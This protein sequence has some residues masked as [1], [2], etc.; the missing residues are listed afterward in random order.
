M[1]MTSPFTTGPHVVA[2][3]AAAATFDTSD[4]HVG[5]A[6]MIARWASVTSGPVEPS[7]RVVLSTTTD[8]AG[9]APATGAT[10]RAMVSRAAAAREATRD[11]TRAFITT[12]LLYTSDAADDLT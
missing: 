12:C 1:T 3:A 7:T 10:P 2:F 5:S 6:R 11:R 8:P 4:E 9:A